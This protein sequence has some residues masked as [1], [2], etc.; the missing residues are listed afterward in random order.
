MERVT[1]AHGQ[2]ALEWNAGIALRFYMQIKGESFQNT[3]NGNIK[4]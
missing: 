4:K 2:V 1:A 3:I